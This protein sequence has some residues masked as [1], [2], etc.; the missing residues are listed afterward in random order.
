[1]DS[2]IIMSSAL[3]PKR[4]NNLGVS[5]DQVRSVNRPFVVTKGGFLCT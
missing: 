5:I 1:M 4:K 2:I 3:M